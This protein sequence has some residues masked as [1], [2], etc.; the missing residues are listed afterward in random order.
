GDEVMHFRDGSSFN[1]LSHSR[2][3]DTGNHQAGF[4]EG[5]YVGSDYASSYQHTVV[6]NVIHDTRFAGD[7]TAEH[8][9]I[10][11]GADGTI[12]EFCTFDGTGISGSNSADS[13]IDVK[14]VNSVIRF[15]HGFRNGNSR[16]VDAFQ[17]RTHGSGYPTGKNNRF[18]RNA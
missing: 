7:I 2:V 10:K 15:N 5:A 14:G 13:F 12:V 11:E 8:I 18:F 16:V 1:T 6:G 4:G 17:V 3:H 9:D